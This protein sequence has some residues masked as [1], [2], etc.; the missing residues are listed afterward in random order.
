MGVYIVA[1]VFYRTFFI[2]FPKG[3]YVS[4]PEEEIIKLGKGIRRL[5]GN[6]RGFPLFFFLQGLL[7]RGRPQIENVQRLFKLCFFRGLRIAGGLPAFA[8]IGDQWQH[9]QQFPT[10]RCLLHWECLHM[11]FGLVHG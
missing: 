9:Y 1:I 11:V 10:L 7:Q 8:V 3:I 5:Q 6:A 2:R 4:P